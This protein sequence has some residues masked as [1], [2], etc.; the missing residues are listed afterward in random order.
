MA[1]ALGVFVVLLGIAGVL[2]W[3]IQVVAWR[4]R[5]A[6]S[7]REKL[8]LAAIRSHERGYRVRFE[9]VNDWICRSRTRTVV[10]ACAYL[11]F[12]LFVAWLLLR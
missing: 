7:M 8:A 12:T 6:S 5:L 4:S 11:F 1:E 9:Y 3:T 10:A 2:L